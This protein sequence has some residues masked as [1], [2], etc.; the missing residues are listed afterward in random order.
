[1]SLNIRK[2]LIISP[3]TSTPFNIFI[4][5]LNK[6]TEKDDMENHPLGFSSTHKKCPTL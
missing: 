6:V 1:M 5:S 4:T 2:Y 3:T